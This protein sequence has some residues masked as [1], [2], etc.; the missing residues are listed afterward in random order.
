QLIEIARGLMGKPRL[1]ILD[2]PT[3]MLT[4]VET[5]RLFEVLQA[6]KRQGVGVIY[7]SH[8]LAELTVISDRTVVLRDGQLVADRPTAQFPE[9]E[10]VRAMVGREPE[11]DLN[12]PRRPRGARVL[13]A[14]GLGWGTQVRDVS[15]DAYAGE[16]LGIAGLVG[17]G[18]TELLRLIFGASRPDAGRIY[19]DEATNPARIDSPAAAVALGIGMVPEDR[20]AQGLLLTQSLAT[21]IT[22]ADVPSISSYGCIDRGKEATIVDGWLRKLRIRARDARQSVAELS[23]GNQ[24]K[25]LLARW[26]YNN[27]RVL[28]LDEPT[29]GVDVGAR[30]DIYAELETLAEAGKALIVVSSDLHEL[31][32]I[33]DRIAV[34]SAGRLVRIFERGEWTEQALLDASF[35]AYG[36]A[37]TGEVTARIS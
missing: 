24:Q 14:E 20:K 17:S 11:H 7:I 22:L 15:F 12:R 10:I 37:A 6:L 33:A 36:K 27:S 31:M 25:V 3:A 34:M 23:G 21:N 1:L 29:R 8:R 18:R 19:L 26:I 30:A 35:A 32:L 2:E 16:V 5:A 28:L 4:A 9:G 13:R